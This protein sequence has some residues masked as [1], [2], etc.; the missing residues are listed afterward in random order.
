MRIKTDVSGF[1]PRR[2][3]GGFMGHHVGG[4]GDSLVPE[5]EICISGYRRV[6]H[7]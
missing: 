2:L 7:A 6:I 5:L 4:V 1:A 3:V